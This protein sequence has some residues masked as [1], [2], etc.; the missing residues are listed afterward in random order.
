MTDYS[1]T[2]RPLLPQGV[3]G[4]HLITQWNILQSPMLQSMH[5]TSIRAPQDP[6]GI[7]FRDFNINGA[8]LTGSISAAETA[9]SSL[10]LLGNN[11]PDLRP[12]LATFVVAPVEIDW[13]ARIQ[14]LKSLGH[15]PLEAERIANTEFAPRV[16]GD[17]AVLRTGVNPLLN[18]AGD[19][20]DFSG[21]VLSLNEV[22]TGGWYTPLTAQ[23]PLYVAKFGTLPL[24][25]YYSVL[26]PSQWTSRIDH[27]L[28]TAGIVPSIDALMPGLTPGAG[29]SRTSALLDVYQSAER[30]LASG[31]DPAVLAN[32]VRAFAAGASPIGD[33]TG[34]DWSQFKKLSLVGIGTGALAFLGPAGDAFAAGV[35][36][37]K[38][39]DQTNEGDHLG[40]ARTWLG[41][42]ANTT[43]SFG[44][45]AFGAVAFSF[46]GPGGAI[47]GALVGGYAGGQAAEDIA[48][49]AFDNGIAPTARYIYDLL[50]ASQAPPASQLSLMDIEG[51]VAWVD[52]SGFAWQTAT[53]DA[54]GFGELTFYR[55]GG[56]VHGVETLQ[57]DGTR[58]T[59]LFD[60]FGREVAQRTETASSGE[61]TIRVTDPTEEHAWS[62]NE[63]TLVDGGIVATRTRLD[64]G[65]TVSRIRDPR[66]DPDAAGSWT[67]TVNYNSGPL[68]GGE[69]GSI[70]GS[71]L[72]QSLGGSNPFARIAASSVLGTLLDNVGETFGDVVANGTTLVDAANSAFHN[73]SAELGGQIR[74]AGIGAISAFLTAELAE[75]IGVD[76]NDFGGALFS[77]ASNTAIGGVANDNAPW[78]EVRDAA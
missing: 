63:A 73:F 65:A 12:A 7:N 52:Q 24:D 46:A 50:P 17:L 76:T 8:P 37:A 36:A 25:T 64:S 34:T 33:V 27:R 44:G 67:T 2:N 48:N 53:G 69:I 40:A 11:H 60:A 59:T 75:E 49:F 16:K 45:V 35:A 23:D 56:G 78:T 10:H 61:Q 62:F 74:S 47:A 9:G 57:P 54:T 70:F 43:G 1:F 55:P 20:V 3:Y 66:S 51:G 4:H 26:D 42:A 71:A 13:N 28:G 19:F 18:A 58:S 32:E 41:W 21:R 77:Y 14:V 38:A 68:L 30:A 31:V 22:R 5:A 15:A 6:G 72:G 29:A 39:I